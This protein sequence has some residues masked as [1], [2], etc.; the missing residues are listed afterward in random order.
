M[1]QTTM[2]TVDSESLVVFAV[3]KCGQFRDL[4]SIPTGDSGFERRE[5][6]HPP[7]LLR[8]DGTTI[9]PQRSGISAG[10]G[11]LQE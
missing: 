4:V 7:T 1:N 2:S 8:E 6:V 5:E 11:R 9:R 3:N 10:V